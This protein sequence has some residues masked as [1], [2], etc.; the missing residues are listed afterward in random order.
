[1]IHVMAPTP[2]RE[3][4]G[5]PRPVTDPSSDSAS[6]NAMLLPAPIDAA[7][8]TTKVCLLRWV[9]KAAATLVRRVLGQA[10]RT[11]LCKLRD[12]RVFHPGSN[13]SLCR[14]E[15]ADAMARAG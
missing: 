6:A 13:K 14:I 7:R 4:H 8:P 9:A 5:E 15:T 12:G 2:R 3:S 10:R 11:A 1:M